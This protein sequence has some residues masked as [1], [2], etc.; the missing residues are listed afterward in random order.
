MKLRLTRRFLL[1]AALLVLSAPAGAAP[2]ARVTDPFRDEH[3]EVKVHLRHLHDM[4]GEMR[5]APAAEA[6]GTM[7]FVVKF[8]NE[9][10]REHAR[11]EEQVLYPV[12]DRLAKSGEHLFTATMR[13]EH[14]IIGRW[15][16]ELAAEAAKDVPGVEAFARR[17]D[18][19]LG[20]VAA[21]FEEEE[22]VLLPLVDRGMS[23]EQFKREVLDHRQAH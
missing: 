22:E 21:H 8:L 2:A 18:N 4:V 11:W 9:H 13:H 16:D 12:V 7:R 19:L 5:T 1:S 3:A 6:P 10:I 23:A 15:I 17:A 20:L 14:V